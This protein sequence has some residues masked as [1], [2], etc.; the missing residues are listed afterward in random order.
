MEKPKS[1][2]ALFVF[3]LGLFF[4]C[5][6]WWSTLTHLVNILWTVDSF[7]HGLLVPFI[8][9]SLI[10]VKRDMLE[11]VRLV[12]DWRG[13][14]L[15]VI[16][17]S[18]WALAVVA[19][20]KIGEH[21]GLIL[22]VQAIAMTCFG[23]A[24]FRQYLFPF[25]FLFLVIPVGD[26]L[27]PI[28]QTVTAEL[29]LFLLSALSVSYEAE[30][31]LITLSSGVFE[32]ARAC[33]G[34]KFLFTSLVMGILLAH[35]AYNSWQRRLTIILVSAVLPIFANALRVFGILLISELSDPEF[36]KGVDH[37]VYGWGFLSV[38][39]FVLVLVAY[40]FSDLEPGPI[41]TKTSS[42]QNCAGEGG[43][44]RLLVYPLMLVSLYL[45]TPL[46]VASVE[47][48]YITSNIDAP[49][50]DN[51]PYRLLTAS[52]SNFLSS[53]QGADSAFEYRYRSAADVITISGALYCAQ[54]P[55]RR[56]LQ[57]GNRLAG[58]EWSILPG[59]G[60]NIIQVEDWKLQKQTFWK[61][62]AR[63]TVY[64]GYFINEKFV[65]APETVKVETALKRLSFENAKGAVFAISIPFSKGVGGADRKIEKFLSAFPLASFLWP[66]MRSI[67]EGAEV[68]AV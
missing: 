30:G 13:L 3:L 65:F 16:A 20:F 34:I 68:C 15:A 7:S 28:L 47:K 41:H 64:F 59:L 18:I 61:N 5:W 6:A 14:F 63:R 31:V 24:F 60:K 1:R 67:S 50:C 56:L 4:L 26:S 40:K 8:S 12:G 33:A 62:S 2:N 22:A 23:F 19:D 37:I 48:K 57:S 29:V 45:V 39:L 46:Q 53:W 52:T 49:H 44:F 27:I 32:V 58:A 25:L 10:W 11:T 55:G 66:G 17:S 54:R 42:I 38:I 43:S 36:A 35:I 51:C 21:A 9:L